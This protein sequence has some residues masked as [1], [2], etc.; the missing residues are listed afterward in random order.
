M[1]VAAC[2]RVGEEPT[3]SFFGDSMIVGPRGTVHARLDGDEPGVAL[4]T[5]DLDEVRAAQEETQ[6]LQ[7]RQ[8]RS[9]RTVVKMY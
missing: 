4:A 1:F 9:Y 2:N 6:L 8:P 7:S 3:Y 5:V